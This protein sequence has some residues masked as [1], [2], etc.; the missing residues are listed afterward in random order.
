MQF[1]C[2][3]GIRSAARL[4][5]LAQIGVVALLLPASPA[6]GAGNE[7]KLVVG[8][9][10]GSGVDAI[11]RVVAERVRTSSA[12]T[13]I[14]ENR[15]GAGGRTA[16]EAVVR[17]EPNGST[18]LFAPIVTTAFSPFLF[19]NLGFDPLHDLAAITR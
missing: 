16:A 13:V 15:P 1:R 3:A 17:A 6:A 19:K 12:H 11:A 2:R 7:L 18:I 8:F 5:L 4:A 10:A 9:A 14:V